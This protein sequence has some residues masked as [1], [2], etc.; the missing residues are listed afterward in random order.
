[1]IQTTRIVPIG[2]ILLGSIA[3]I[4]LAGVA[5]SSQSNLTAHPIAQTALTETSA[6]QLKP[7]CSQS[8]GIWLGKLCKWQDLLEE[9]RELNLDRE[10]H[11]R[12]GVWQT[13]Y[14]EV[15]VCQG[16]VCTWHYDGGNVE[17]VETGIGCV[18]E[19]TKT[20]R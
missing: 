7:W 2:L 4:D 8:G 5:A 19:N 1:M 11:D 15:V 16:D 3:S 10:C 18:W 9:E 6:A 20:E 17:Y 14:E 13:L 12:G